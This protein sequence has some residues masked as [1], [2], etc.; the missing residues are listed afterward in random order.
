MGEMFFHHLPHWHVRVEQVDLTVTFCEYANMTCEIL[1]A[2]YANTPRLGLA[3]ELRLLTDVFYEFMSLW[4]TL[5][6]NL[7]GY[8]QAKV[9]PNPDDQSCTIDAS[10]A[11]A[12]MLPF[13]TKPLPRLSY[14]VIQTRMKF[15]GRLGSRGI[16]PVR[17]HQA[18][19]ACS[20][21][22]CKRHTTF[23]ICRILWPAASCLRRQCR[24]P[25]AGT[26]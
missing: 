22:C 9:L 25:S 12:L 21:C 7:V 6:T 18:L 5:V 11:T 8:R 10:P 26:A 4:G 15:A 23:A 16:D 3:D 20:K 14:N 13:Y 2:K 17:G 24:K 19:R 1:F